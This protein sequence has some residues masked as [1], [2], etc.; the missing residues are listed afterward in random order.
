MNAVKSRW[1]NDDVACLKTMMLYIVEEECDLEI[2]DELNF[3]AVA[4][5]NIVLKDRSGFVLRR[6]DFRDPAGL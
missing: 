3:L 2:A 5:M 4:G 1:R 6:E